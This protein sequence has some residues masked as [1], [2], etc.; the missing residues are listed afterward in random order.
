MAKRKK[1]GGREA[2]TKNKVSSPE[3]EQA[4]ECFENAGG[5]KKIFSLIEIV[6]EDSPKDAAGLMLKAVEFFLP[7]QKAVEHKGDST[8][9]TIS[10]N[11]QSTHVP[12]ITSENDMFDDD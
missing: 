11:F 6:A 12:P 10:V 3:K 4:K 2:G 1:T 7:K 9:G 8:L 5:F